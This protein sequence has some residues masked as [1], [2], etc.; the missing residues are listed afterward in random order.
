MEA[1]MA[2]FSLT[3]ASAPSQLIV[4]KNLS[5]VSSTAQHQNEF[6]TALEAGARFAFV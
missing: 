3:A 5:L 6:C 1:I 2:L 4:S